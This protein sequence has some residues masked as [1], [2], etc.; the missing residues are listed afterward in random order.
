[1]KDLD[2]LVDIEKGDELRLALAPNE[3]KYRLDLNIKYPNNSIDG[4]D[5]KIFGHIESK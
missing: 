4:S 1:M 3:K 2:L 5:I